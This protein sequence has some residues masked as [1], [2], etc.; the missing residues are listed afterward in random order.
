MVIWGRYC[1]AALTLLAPVT[2]VAATIEH[3]PVRVDHVVVERFAGVLTIELASD[4]MVHFTLDA[5]QEVLDNARYE[6]EQGGLLISDVRQ[7]GNQSI[8]VTGDVQAIAEGGGTA[9][10]TIGNSNAPQEPTILRLQVPRGT[11]LHLLDLTGTVSVADVEA[12][13]DLVAK[14]ASVTLGRIGPSSLAVRGSGSIEAASVEG[15]LSLSIQGGGQIGVTSGQVAALKIDFQGSGNIT[16]AGT[17]ET[18]LVRGQGAGRIT[19]GEVKT[20]ADVDVS[21]A[22]SVEITKP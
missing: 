16:F 21:G 15:D 6:V 11:A 8:V 20:P 17:A 12:P 2:G 3:Q 10:V 19:I 14:S 1:L 5:P 18:A 22:L 13:V 7:S 4:E 9:Q